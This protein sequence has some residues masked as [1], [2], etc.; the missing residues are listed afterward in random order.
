MVICWYNA[1][2]EDGNPGYVPDYSNG[3]LLAFFAQ[4][5]NAYGQYVFGHQDMHDCL[6][7][8]DWHFYYDNNIQYPSTDGLYVKWVNKINIYTGNCFRL[9][10]GIIWR[11]E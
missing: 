3:M 11:T 2:P 10:C 4:T 5:T 6:P 1:C 8:T 7:Q 9:D